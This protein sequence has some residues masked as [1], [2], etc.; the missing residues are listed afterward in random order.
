MRKYSKS[1]CEISSVRPVLIL[2]IFGLCSKKA[3]VTGTPYRI[4]DSPKDSSITSTTEPLGQSNR[5]TELK[6]ESRQSV[7]SHHQS[8]RDVSY[9]IRALCKKYKL[10]GMYFRKYCIN[11]Y[12]HKISKITYYVENHCQC[13]EFAYCDLCE[14]IWKWEWDHMYNDH[15]KTCPICNRLKRY[16]LAQAE[17]FALYSHLIPDNDDLN[18]F[19]VQK[20]HSSIFGGTSG[21]T[22]EKLKPVIETAHAVYEKMCEK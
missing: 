12:V 2:H 14:D 13:G 22:F 10:N 6:T 3:L 5:I 18:D 15:D 4:M 20:E 1:S 16:Y 11:K 17:F 21:L 8:T 9:I 19:Y 7:E